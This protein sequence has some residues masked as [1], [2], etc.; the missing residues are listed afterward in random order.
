MAEL[1]LTTLTGVE[2]TGYVK[3]VNPG[4]AS[5]ATLSQLYLNRNHALQVNSREALVD[6]WTREGRVFMATTPVQGV[7]ETMSAAG[8]AI[9]LTDPSLRFTVP[10]GQVVVP[11]SVQISGHH[12]T[13][14]HAIFQ[15]L[16]TAS[17]S[18]TSGGDA[19]LMTPLNALINST[20][21]A[22]GSSITKLHYSDT[23]IVEAALV[24]PRC[25]KSYLKNATA[26]DP[27]D[28][29]P[30]YNI[31]KGDPMVYMIGPASF[32]VYVVEE[33]AALEAEWTMMWAELEGGTVP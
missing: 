3:Q 6:Q 31:M 22:R 19:V 25:L 8:T 26:T 7:P 2:L 30:E 15:V 11:I 1:S 18:Y 14:K 32:L 5:D 29:C 4:V 13:A 16:A 21:Q 23:A 20:T 12:T 17:D 27:T 33:T 28:W 24:G 9:V 10:S